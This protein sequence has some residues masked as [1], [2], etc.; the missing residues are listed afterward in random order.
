MKNLL[1]LLCCIT[2]LVVCAQKKVISSGTIRFESK[3]NMH[4][5]MENNG[6]SS[7][8]WVEEQ[9]KRMPKYKV[10]N[11]DL[12]FNSNE[13]LFKKSKDQP[14]TDNKRMMM[15][16]GDD[17]KNETYKNIDSNTIVAAKQIFEEFRLIEDKMITAEWKLTN[18]YRTIAGFNCRRATAIIMDSLFVVAFYTDAITTQ[19]G[20]EGLNGLPGMIL[21]LAVPRL[22]LTYFATEI[23]EKKD[24]SAL[25]KAPQKGKKTTY[26]KLDNE[27]TEA[28]KNWG[29]WGGGRNTMWGFML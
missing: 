19:S 24:N 26:K 9:K 14:P 28:T 20:P 2:S 12:F 25:I 10:V 16:G 11:Y 15:M 13:S 23:D 6:G 8:P 5:M 22:N 7:N 3:I 27:V 29:K 17:E 1:M 18:E 21:G 4:K